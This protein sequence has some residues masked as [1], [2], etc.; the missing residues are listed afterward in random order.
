MLVSLSLGEAG[1]VTWL[2]KGHSL[3]LSPAVGAVVETL[4]FLLETEVP[5]R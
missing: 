2:D 4:R 1:K 3:T 5:F